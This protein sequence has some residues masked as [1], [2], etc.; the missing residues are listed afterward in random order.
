MDA[1]ITTSGLT[2]YYGSTRGV[3]DLDLEV[4]HGEVFGFIGPNGAG[5][6]TT[7]RLLLDLIRPT[8]GTAVVLGRDVTA[9]S[10]EIRRRI[11]YLPGE[12]AMFGSMTGHELVRFFGALRRT[13]ARRSAEILADRLDLDL[14][15]R[16]KDYSSG[17]RQKLALVQA[18]MHEPELLILDEPTNALDPL[19]QQEFYRMLDEVGAAGRTVFL[20]SHL[21]P[22]IERV[23]DR[24]GIIR[25]GT[26]VAVESVAG[27]KARAL[28]RIEFRFA[29][30]LTDIDPFVHVPGVKRTAI[31]DDGVVAQV[32]V[33]GSVDAVLKAAA[34]YEIVSLVSHDGDL[35][36]AFLTY[37]QAVPD[38]S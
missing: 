37:Y 22:E 35:E 10:L 13:D 6:T 1:V 16:I 36:E 5:K 11:G 3:E 7:L 25:H 28:R 27:L 24:V 15:R 18:F 34:A 31:L 12:L 2:K 20:S 14:T 9:D 4:R 8:R 19:I 38:A 21:L 23:A 33:E 17:N 30:P 29:T 32:V 26:L